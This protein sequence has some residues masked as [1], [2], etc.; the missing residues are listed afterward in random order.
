MFKTPL[1]TQQFGFLDN[2]KKFWDIF[3]VRLLEPGLPCNIE[4]KDQQ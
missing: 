1:V 4:S 2:S 3:I